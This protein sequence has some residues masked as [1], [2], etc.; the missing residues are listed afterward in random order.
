[1]NYT[2]NI[3][4]KSAGETMGMPRKG[5]SSCNL[6]SPVTMQ[7]AF[8]AIAS[9][10]NLSSSGSRQAFMSIVGSIKR[11]IRFTLPIAST[12]SSSGIYFLN[13]LRTKRVA[14]SSKIEEEHTMVPVAI[15]LSKACVLTDPSFSCALIK[16]FVSKTKYLVILFQQLIKNF[17]C[18]ASFGSILSQAIEERTILGQ[19]FLHTFIMCFNHFVRRASIARLRLT[20]V[21]YFCCF[22]SFLQNR[23]KFPLLLLC[24][25][26]PLFSSGLV[27]FYHNPFHTNPFKNQ[28]QR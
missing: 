2:Q 19:F 18:K 9:D 21:F 5:W 1:M 4:K 22:Q 8:M 13:F 26:A 25:G 7:F 10:K 3:F 6:P 11:E 28:Y 16:A 20:H 14:N 12:R 24:A 15:A 27:Y 17:L 23:G